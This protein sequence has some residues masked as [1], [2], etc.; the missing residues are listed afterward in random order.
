LESGIKRRVRKYGGNHIG[1][2]AEALG[3]T[4]DVV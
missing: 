4:K 3:E 1:H 2:V